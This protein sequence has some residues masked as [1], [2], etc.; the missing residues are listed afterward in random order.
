MKNRNYLSCVRSAEFIPHETTKY[1]IVNRTS[2]DF[3]L[4]MR[5][6]FRIA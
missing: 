6:K 2:Q 5:N 3:F 1:F 4:F